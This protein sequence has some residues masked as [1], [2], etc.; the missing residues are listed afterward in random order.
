[1]RPTHLLLSQRNPS[2]KL[3]WWAMRIQELD[4]KTYHRL[5]KSNL[6][7]DAL[8]RHPLPVADVL[9]VVADARVEDA[10]ENDID[11]LQRQV[12]ELGAIFQWLEGG[13]L[14]V[15]PH[16]AQCLKAEHSNLEIIDGVLC[17]DRLSAP[18]I[19]RI[20]VPRCLRSTL[21]RESYSGK[22]AGHFAEQKIYPFPLREV[23]VE[24][25]E[26]QCSL[27]LPKL[28]GLCLKERAWKVSLP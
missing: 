15:D 11:K 25:H 10:P 1:M 26:E 17:Y 7:A 2:P 27:L 18:D 16:Q 8:S 14:Q 23:M 3:A 6:V 21:L 20:V 5:G 4:L 22:F 19:V 12:D 28:P 9:Q 24:R 13:G